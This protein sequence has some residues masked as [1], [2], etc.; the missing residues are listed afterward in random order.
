MT[1]IKISCNLQSS[2]ILIDRKNQVFGTLYKLQ[3]LYFIERLSFIRSL[4]PLQI[5]IVF[6]QIKQPLMEIFENDLFDKRAPRDWAF[7]N[8]FLNFT[9]P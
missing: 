8:L 3:K 6:L 7:K 9:P 4:R 2:Q 5:T 1:L